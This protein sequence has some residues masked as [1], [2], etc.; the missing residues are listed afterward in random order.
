MSRNNSGVTL[1]E[2]LVVIAII[3]ILVVALG[4]S[5]EGWIGKY[6]IENQ[7]K[8]IFADIMDARSRTMTRNRAHFITL[9][10][11]QYTI[12]EDL[13][14]WPDGNGVL[15]ADDSSRPSGYSETIPL[16]QKNIADYTLSIVTTG[17]SFPQTVTVDKRGFLSPEIDF[18]VVSNRDPDYDCVKISRVRVR[19]G[20][21]NGTICEDR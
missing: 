3:S 8:D 20:K 16:M 17:L 15:T 4:F 7:T 1:I 5:F 18:R 9:G 21:Y 13:D 19:M 2:L 10:A 14:P 12:Q 11:N 6:R